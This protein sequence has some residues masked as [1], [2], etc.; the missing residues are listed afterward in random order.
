MTNEELAQFRTHYQGC[1]LIL[2][3]D[4]STLTI[5]GSDSAIRLGQEHLDALCDTAHAIF[6]R[7]TDVTRA[8]I[9]KPG[10]RRLFLRAHPGAVEVIAGVFDHQVDLG[11]ASQAAHE[12][13]AG[14]GALP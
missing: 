12:M 14:H 7:C 9:C 4:L 3:A 6:S 2:F 8:C 5:L 11:H 1:E 13:L 10:G